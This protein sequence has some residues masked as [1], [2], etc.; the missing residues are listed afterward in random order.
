M[1]LFPRGSVI[2]RVTL[3]PQ[4]RHP[5]CRPFLGF[6]CRPNEPSSIGRV[7]WLYQ[8]HMIPLLPTIVRESDLQDLDAFT[9]RWTRLQV[10]A[11]V[12]VQQIEPSR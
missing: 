9:R 3:S 11:L 5:A 4:K 7:S 12:G 2:R 8:V 1:T 6:S 10:V